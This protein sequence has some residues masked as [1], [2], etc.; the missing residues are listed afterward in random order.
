[1][2]DLRPGRI[3][4]ERL[5]ASGVSGYK[6]S[7]CEVCALMIYEENTTK[8]TTVSVVFYTV[9]IKKRLVFEIQISNNYSDLIVLKCV[10]LTIRGKNVSY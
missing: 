9:C 6:G 8:I 4:W 2:A 3:A 7:S 5:I 1:M 10:E